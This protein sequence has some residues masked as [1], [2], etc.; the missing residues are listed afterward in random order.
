[1]PYRALF[2]TCHVFLIGVAIG[3][4]VWTD[5]D[6]R[7]SLRYSVVCLGQYCLGAESLPGFM[8]SYHSSIQIDC[9]IHLANVVSVRHDR[10][11]TFLFLNDIEIFKKAQTEL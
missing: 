5:N 3:L 6:R 11:A 4:G 8:Y 9:I 2:F 7:N 10:V 1:M